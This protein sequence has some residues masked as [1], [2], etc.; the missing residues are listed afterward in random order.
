MLTHIDKDINRLKS[1]IQ[2]EP[3]LHMFADTGA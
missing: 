2:I 3:M 1:H